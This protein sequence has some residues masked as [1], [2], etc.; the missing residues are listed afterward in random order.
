MK[1]SS[2]SSSKKSK[3]LPLGHPDSV[4]CNLLG[5]LDPSQLESERVWLEKVSPTF[6]EKDKQKE[7]EKKKKK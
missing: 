5:S 7:Q 3:R 6:G 4:E 1:N 2:S